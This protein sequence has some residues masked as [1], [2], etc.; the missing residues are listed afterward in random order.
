MENFKAGT[1]V[2]RSFYKSFEPNPI[3][4]HWQLSNL[5]LINLLT[6]ADRAL[7]K[8]DMYS[9]Y[10]P[11][12]DLFI[13]MHIAKEA[14]LSNKIEGTQTNIEDAVMEK[15]DLN[16]EK[17]DDW[18][19]VNNYIK[20]MNA[21]INDLQKLPFSSRL[22]RQ[23]HGILL[24]SAR[25]SNKMPGEFRQSQNWIGGYNI[26]SASFVPPLHENIQML[27][28]DVEKFAHADELQLPNLLKIAIMH[29]QFETIHPFLDGNGRI[30]RLMIT[31][32]LVSKA[33][34]QKPLLYLSDFL[35][36]NRLQYYDLLTRVREKDD[37][38]SWCK[39]FLTGVIETA[40]KSILTFDK[41][42]QLEKTVNEKLKQL[43]SKQKKAELVM[44]YLYKKPVI[45]PT[46]TQLVIGSKNATAYSLL[47]DL[48][49]LGILKEITG[50]QRN[51]NY[52]FMEYV[53]IFR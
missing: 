25:G 53:D 43:G 2:N 12:I 47:T 34:L 46:T 42:L 27:M 23:A 37:L 31:L 38:I 39:F 22:I 17:R 50:N 7:G 10:V 24:Q 52:M 6:T 1:L 36:R 21:A 15:T 9:K 13:S 45:N 5:E 49:Q 40:E 18:E 33:L 20:A 51:R 11:N 29:Y 3:H 35:E 32:F 41:I 28:A 14:T 26:D 19:E 44:Q 30:G 16:T 48:E 4:R 8:L